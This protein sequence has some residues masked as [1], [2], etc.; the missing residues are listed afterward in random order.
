MKDTSKINNNK[1]WEKQARK[2]EKEFLQHSQKKNNIYKD[3]KKTVEMEG[4]RKMFVD[5]T[6]LKMINVTKEETETAKELLIDNIF[7][8]SRKKRKEM[9]L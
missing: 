1:K 3:G 8:K 6:D 4:I 2:K 9:A 5:I 7:L